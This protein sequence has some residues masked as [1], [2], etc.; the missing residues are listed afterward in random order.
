MVSGTEARVGIRD[1]GPISEYLAA[2]AV[3]EGAFLPTPGGN[4]GVP[5]VGRGRT[6]LR[7]SRS[8]KKPRGTLG[9]VARLEEACDGDVA[10]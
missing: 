3:R 7:S 6:P 9:Y 5:W 4:R 2:K 10:Q 1:E 8:Q